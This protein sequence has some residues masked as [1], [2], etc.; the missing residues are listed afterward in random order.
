MADDRTYIKLHD[1]MP[2][3]P[4][5]R[6]LSDKAFRA[7]VSA[8]CYCSQYRTDGE[9]VTAV[10]RD[11]GTP[12]AW[13]E[14]V[15]AGLAQTSGRGYTMHDYLE[16]Q[17]SAAQIE[18]LAEKRRAAGKLGGRP[19]GSNPKAKANQDENQEGKQEP[20]QNGSKKNPETESLPNGRDQTETDPSLRS[21]TAQQRGTRIPDDFE[22]DNPLRQWARDRGFT[23]PQ[24]D[25]VTAAFTRY[26][27]AKSGRD[28]TKLDWPA[29]WQN[30]VAKED[31][32]RVRIPAA[33]GG[34][35]LPSWEV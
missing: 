29:T 1:G 33:A 27:R 2:N 13:R 11:L 3:H 16:H 35:Q 9:V 7:F 32:R 24:I 5:V 15:A 18:E 17:R 34:R 30:W 22:P 4:K 14:L 6:G 25:E 20:K 8:L 21:G 31:P 26:W 12:A 23:D 19:R 10:A 28:A